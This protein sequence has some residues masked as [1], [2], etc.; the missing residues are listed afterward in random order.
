MKALSKRAGGTRRTGVVLALLMAFAYPPSLRAAEEGALYSLMLVDRLEYQTNEGDSLLVWDAQGWLGGDSDKFWFKTEGEQALGGDLEEAEI[1]GLYSRAITSFW[2]LQMGVRYD[3]EHGPSRTYGVIGVQGLAPYW[4]E[5]DAA[6]FVSE[7][8]DLSARIEVEYDV[9][10]TQRLIAQPRAELNFAFQDVD[11][12]GVGSGLSTAELGLR[13]RY[14]IERE[15]APYVGV[16]WTRSLGSTAD[17]ARD[18][19]GNVS[20]VSFVA[21]IRLWF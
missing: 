6:L 4:F 18:D 11:E 2:D 16:S 20:S 17:F 9:L 21:G 14:E 19:G 10:I 7:H 1:Q 12:L 8:G 3:F 15:F 13:L 5:I